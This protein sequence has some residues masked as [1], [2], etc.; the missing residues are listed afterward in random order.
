MTTKC[1]SELFSKFKANLDS[2][3]DLE[4]DDLT[5]AYDWL[6]LNYV[7]GYLYLPYLDLE[8]WSDEFLY[9]WDKLNSWSDGVYYFESSFPSQDDLP[10]DHYSN[11]QDV[12]NHM[13][14]KLSEDDSEDRMIGCV[15]VT[16]GDSSLWVLFVDYSSWSFGEGHEVFVSEALNLKQKDGFYEIP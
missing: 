13:T 10:S 6:G 1:S 14:A 4:G 15:E 7:G 9:D 2:W 11:L 8:S 5:E 3:V 12:L 16:D